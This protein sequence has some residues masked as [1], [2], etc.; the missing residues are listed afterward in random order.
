MRETVLIL[1]ISAIF[2]MISSIVSRQQAAL[3]TTNVVQLPIKVASRQ[4][5][6][7][8]DANLPP[9]FHAVNGDSAELMRAIIAVEYISISWIEHAVEYTIAQIAQFTGIPLPDLSY[10]VAQ[11]RPSTYSKLHLTFRGSS[12][13]ALDFVNDCVSIAIGHKV[14]QSLLEK[15]Q[16]VR[17]LDAQRL[18]VIRDYTGQLEHRPEHL[19]HNAIVVQ[20]YNDYKFSRKNKVK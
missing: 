6:D 10:G 12:P 4:I 13:E 5:A 15:Y 8:A 18:E 16:H 14:I 3:H 17:P 1:L 20:L 7:Y 19:I 9:C 11:V 2:F